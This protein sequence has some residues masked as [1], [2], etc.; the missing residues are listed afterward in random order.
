MPQRERQPCHL[1][2]EDGEVFTGEAFGAIR[3]ADGEVGKSVNN[4]HY[5]HTTVY[6]SFVFLIILPY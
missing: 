6:M 3:P 5:L 2:L 1:L 4:C